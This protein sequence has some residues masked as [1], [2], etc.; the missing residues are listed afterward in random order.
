MG[1]REDER[2]RAL[3]EVPLFE[4]DPEN[5]PDGVRQIGNKEMANLGIDRD[6]AFYWNGRSVKVDKILVLSWWQKASAVIVTVTAALVALSTI[7]QGVAAYN[8]W[9]CTVEW[10]AVCPVVPLVQN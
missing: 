9:A 3:R 8:A 10:L 1:Y 5:W 7:L 6:G 2:D 4:A